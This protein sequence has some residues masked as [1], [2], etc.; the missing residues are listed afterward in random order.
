MAWCGMGADIL[1]FYVADLKP[2]RKGLPELERREIVNKVRRGV[3][4]FADFHDEKMKEMER[5]AH[6][7]VQQE[8][9]AMEI[10]RS[11]FSTAFELQNEA[12]AD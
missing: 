3:A 10:E 7:L 12:I 9:E 8:R 6:N 5:E 2:L 4:L 1:R 11:A